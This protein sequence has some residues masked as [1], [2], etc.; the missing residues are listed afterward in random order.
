MQKAL[1]FKNRLCFKDINKDNKFK[2]NIKDKL[3]SLDTYEEI[4]IVVGA[5]KIL[6]G[7]K[8]HVEA[9][10]FLKNNRRDS[11]QNKIS[12]NNLSESLQIKQ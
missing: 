6:G 4:D 5:P 10:L 7:R 12:S 11:A 3:K 8:S 1:T 9:A 2:N